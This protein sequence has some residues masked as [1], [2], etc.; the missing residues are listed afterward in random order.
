MRG[1]GRKR[2]LGTRNGHQSRACAEPGEARHGCGAAL[3]ARAGD[4]QQMSELA[5]VRIPGAR[6][7]KRRNAF[8]RDKRKPDPRVVFKQGR[9]RTDRRNPQV[10][11][12]IAGRRH[13]VAHLRCGEGDGRIGAYIFA[14]YRA[15]FAG[16]PRRNIH[17][18]H[19]RQREA[20]DLADGIE[21]RSLRRPFQAG[22]EN[23]IDHKRGDSDLG[24]KLARCF[25]AAGAQHSQILRGIA[26]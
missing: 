1:D 16:K 2:G 25:D 12:Q 26:L 21:C 22:A 4:D 9:P 19:I 5:L 13:G 24:S 6:C 10:A 15:R 3:T 23:R 20:V 8:G 14:R 18:D 17:G 11:H 7:K